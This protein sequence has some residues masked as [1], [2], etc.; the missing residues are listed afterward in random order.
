MAKDNLLFKLDNLEYQYKYLTG[1]ISTFKPRYNSTTKFYNAKGKK[2]SKKVETILSQLNATQLSQKIIDLKFEI[3]NKKIHHLEKILNNLIFK[4]LNANLHNET[5]KN[6]NVLKSIEK[7]FTL[8]NFV[9]MIIK[10]KIIKLSISKFEE[11]LKKHHDIDQ[12]KISDI[13]DPVELWFHNHEYWTFYNDKTNKFNPSKIWKDVVLTVEKSD[14]IISTM[15][16]SKKLK[17]LLSNFNS[18]LDVFLNINKDIKKN[19]LDDDNTTNDDKIK[20]KSQTSTSTK[21]QLTEEELIEQYDGLLA[22]S[23]DE[24]SDSSIIDENV[25]YNEVTS[26]EDT[27]EDNSN[28]TEKNLKSKNNVDSSSNDNV[29]SSSND[30]DSI[31]LPKA[32]KQKIQLPELMGGYY[33]GDDDEEDIDLVED[34]LAKKQISIEPVKKNRRGQRARRKIW[35]QKY[36]KEAKHIQRELKKQYE[37]RQQRQL[38]YEARVAKRAARAAEDEAY[39]KEQEE[40]KEFLNSIGNSKREKKPVAKTNAMENHP[41]WVAKKLAAEKLQ[42]TKFKGKK[43]TF[44]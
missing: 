13:K 18:G 10:S 30:D 35:E 22:A 42:N 9:Q 4:Q 24:E 15:M 8:Q 5:Y 26:D 20:S 37:E 21:R 23:D 41:S 19:K 29:D 28:I 33:S 40:R 31:K 3:F 11:A 38:E 39:R 34:K 44:D 32:K 7:I 12:T 43:I 14:Q 25:N 1:N 2:T 16:N 6:I 27:I 36:G 17:D